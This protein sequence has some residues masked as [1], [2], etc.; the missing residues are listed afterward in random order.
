MIKYNSLKTIENIEIEG[1]L[2]ISPEIYND[3]RGFFFESWNREKFSNITKPKT[4]FVQDNHS[5]SQKGVLRGLH[6]Q[7]NP[8]AQGKLIRC[9]SGE[10]FDVIIDLRVKSKTFSKWSGVF[11]SQT[12][13]KELWI[14]EGFAHGFLTISDT[15]EIIYKTT[16]YWNKNFERS[17][18]WNDKTLSINWPLNYLKTKS[19]LLSP[20]DKNAPTLEQ[21]IINSDIF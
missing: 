11:L 13:F 19:P 3:S 17:I 14:P 10:I 18:I 20:K 15:A 5:K 1:P 7:L 6:Y 9:I 8:N 2:L 4:D 12:N 21:A 16:N